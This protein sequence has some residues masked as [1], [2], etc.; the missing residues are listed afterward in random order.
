MDSTD[1]SKND[2]A[3]R[4]RRLRGLTWLGLT[5]FVAIAGA[6]ASDNSKSSLEVFKLLAKAGSK[7]IGNSPPPPIVIRT[8]PPTLQSLKT[9]LAT[10]EQLLNE[11][12]RRR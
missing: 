11:K 1:N 5:C 12:K 8:K 6:H 10:E 4:L 9:Q 2:Q 3:G 7:P